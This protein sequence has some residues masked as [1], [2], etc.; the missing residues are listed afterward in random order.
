ML[1][2]KVFQ[3]YLIP[4]DLLPIGFGLLHKGNKS[5]ENTTLEGLSILRNQYKLKPKYVL[6]DGAFGTQKLTKRL[7]DYRW[8]L[9][10]KG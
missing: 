6:A 8:G 4:A 5:Q 7:D 1:I 3:L 10:Y 2:A 9:C